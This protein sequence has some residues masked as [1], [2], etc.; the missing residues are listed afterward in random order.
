MITAQRR[1]TGDPGCA[2]RMDR[3]RKRASTFCWLAGGVRDCGVLNKCD[4]VED[5]ELL[6][7]VELEVRELLKSYQFPGDTIPVIKG[8]ALQA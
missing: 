5:A 6:E 2:A 8:S 7:L 3:C 4:M 1:W